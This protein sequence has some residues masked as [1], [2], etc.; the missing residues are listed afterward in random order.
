MIHTKSSAELKL[1]VLETHAVLALAC[2][3]LGLLFQAHW[4]FFTAVFFLVVYLLFFRLAQWI[5]NLWLAFSEVLGNIMSIFLLSL[6]YVGILIP[7][8]WLYRIFHSDELDLQRGKDSYY[9][10]RDVKFDKSYFERLW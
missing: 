7:V 4:L 1:K 9:Y 2:M 3:I 10:K 6:C 8:S 5:S